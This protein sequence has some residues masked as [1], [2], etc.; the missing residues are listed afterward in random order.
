MIQ[1]IQSLYLLVAALAAIAGLKLTVFTQ[2][3]ATTESGQGLATPINGASNLYLT[4]A[5]ISI[6]VVSLLAIFFYKNRKTQIKLAITAMVL[7]FALWGLYI[8]AYIASVAGTW[9]LSALSIILI[10]IL[11]IQAIRAIKKDE[12]LIKSLDRLR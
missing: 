9:S 10:P 2:L 8:D 7:G 6:V 4:A 12:A 1:R 11:H 5:H 3:D